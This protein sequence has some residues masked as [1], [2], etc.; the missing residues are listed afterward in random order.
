VGKPSPSH[1]ALCWTLCLR[2]NTALLPWL[3]VTQHSVLGGLP[4]YSAMVHFA[5]GRGH[6]YPGSSA[7]SAQEKQSSIRAFPSHRGHWE[8]PASAARGCRRPRCRAST[9]FLLLERRRESKDP[10]NVLLFARVVFLVPQG[11][12]GKRRV[13][14]HSQ[15]GSPVLEYHRI[16]HL[17]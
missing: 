10:R 2:E 4:R 12:C 13:P 16:R 17:I 7:A 15:P 8:T 14:V 9:S 1:R 6:G 3:S 5:K 11:R